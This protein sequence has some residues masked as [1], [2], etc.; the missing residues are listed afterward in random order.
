[1]SEGQS[2][3]VRKLVAVTSLGGFLELYDFSIYAIMANHIASHFF[4][5]DDPSIS[6]LLTFATFTVGYFGRPL[7]GLIFGH[8]GDRYGRKKTFATTVLL[9]A[10]STA[11]IGILPDYS[12]IGLLAPVL[13]IVLRIVQG[14]SLGGELPGAIT[15]ISEARPE[16]RGFYCGVLYMALLNALALC[17][18]IQWLLSSVLGQQMMHDWGWRI[19]FLFGGCLGFVS[20]QIRR[21]CHESGL[22][23]LLEQTKQR[24]SIPAR[25]V[26]VKYPREL[27]FGIIM[28]AF[29]GSAV[30]FYG[31]YMQGFIVRNVG[32]EPGHFAGILALAY[33]LSSPVCL[34]GKLVDGRY[35]RPLFILL[36]LLV[37]IGSPLFLH[38][39]MSGAASQ[40]P[41]AFGIA[42]SCALVTGTIPA[43][44]ADLFPT[45]VRYS[46]VALAYNLGF[47][48]FG[49][50]APLIATSLIEVTGDY[51]SP[52]LY[53][54]ATSM[55]ALLFALFSFRSGIFSPSRQLA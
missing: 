13:L 42:M 28:V 11:L 21:Q 6:L 53:L 12:Q 35:R 33:M 30:I 18:I 26:L 16:K 51:R 49:G 36:G 5:A 37:L 10:L 44:L 50:T 31:Q 32:F 25:T 55:V 22:Y 15:Y 43:M 8:L 19:P 1:M 3:S 4:P 38:W 54:M 27:I 23:Q 24:E 14:F 48:F 46:G 41:A 45:S 20:Y 2:T 47:S 40:V 7:G 9:M 34:I 52:A 29:C 17:C 39:L